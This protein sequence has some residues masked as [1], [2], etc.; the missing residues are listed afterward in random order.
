[1][2]LQDRKET[3]ALRVRR[4]PPEPKVRRA[5]RV[6][7]VPLV[8]TGRMAKVP[9]RLL[10]IAASPVPSASGLH[11][12]LVRRAHRAQPG[13]RAPP[14]LRE[15]RGLKVPRVTSAPLEA[16]VLRD[17]RARLEQ[18]DPPGLK[19]LRARMARTAKARINSPRKMASSDP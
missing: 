9:I 3:R 14:E 13:Q 2:V 8:K 15:L 10:R 6:R 7:R 4:E 12:S 5:T 1:M 17:R 16:S 19:V 18:Q 11:R